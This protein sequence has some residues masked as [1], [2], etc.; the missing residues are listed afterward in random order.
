MGTK[1]AVFFRVSYHILLKRRREFL[2]KTDLWTRLQDQIAKNSTLPSSCTVADASLFPIIFE[3]E[4]PCS[5]DTSG[6]RKS[7]SKRTSRRARI[8]SADTCTTHSQSAI[9]CVSALDAIQLYH[10][11][12]PATPPQVTTPAPAPSSAATDRQRKR[13]SLGS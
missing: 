2:S 10:D 5:N 9:F 13:F 1:R 8:G 11:S 12:S 6:K 4:T 3:C 7:A